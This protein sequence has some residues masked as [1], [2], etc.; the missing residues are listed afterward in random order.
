VRRRRRKLRTK[1]KKT[2]A[3][4]LSREPP[5]IFVRRDWLAGG[6]AVLFLH[7]LTTTPTFLLIPP[8]SALFYCFGFV[9]PLFLSSSSKIVSYVQ[10]S[11]FGL[12][13]S[14]VE[15]KGGS[16]FCFCSLIDLLC[17]LCFLFFSFLPTMSLLRSAAQ[18]TRENVWV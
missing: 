6:V 8:G 14:H 18:Y 10:I 3:L 13:L 2:K 1:M 4:C 11:F 7:T 12:L 9:L 16:P 15:G 5:F 17:R